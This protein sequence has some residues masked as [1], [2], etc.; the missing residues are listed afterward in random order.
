MDH[1]DGIRRHMKS[2]ED[3]YGGQ[4]LGYDEIDK[5][6]SEDDLRKIIN[7]HEAHMESMLSDAITHLRNF[8]QRIGI[9]LYKRSARP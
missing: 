3:F 4:L 5:A 7:E 2:F 8:E 9:S 6:E 1:L